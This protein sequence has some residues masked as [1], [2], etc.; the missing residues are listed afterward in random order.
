MPEIIT[1]SDET[2]HTALISEESSA[3]SSDAAQQLGS[4]RFT[5]RAGILITSLVALTNLGCLIWASTLDIEDGS[6]TIFEGSCK[7][8]KRITFWVDLAIN[9][10]STL[11]LG[12]SNNCTQLLVAPT[13]KDIDDAHAAGKYLDVGVSSMRNV[14]AVSRWRQ[15]LCACLFLSS[16]PLHLLYNSVIFST[17]SAS[18]YMAAVV[19]DDFLE[20]AAWNNSRLDLLQESETTGQRQLARL[21]NST[22]QLRRLENKDCIRA[23]GTNVLQ[24]SWKNV[25]V[26]SDANV[27]GPLIRA[28]YH[29][30]DLAANDLSWICG[31]QAI[32]VTSECDTKLMLSNPR[33]WTIR[34]MET[35]QDKELV[36]GLGSS[37]YGSSMFGSGPTGPWFEASVQ[38]CLAEEAKERCGVK[39][40]TP[41]LGTVLLCNLIKVA[42]LTYALLVRDFDPMATVGDLISSYLDDH[43]PYTHGRGPIAD[44]DVRFKP[45]RRLLNDYRELSMET[46]KGNNFKIY[47]LSRMWK[48]GVG[49]VSVN[50]LVGATN[51]RSLIENVLL[52]NTPQLA[53]SF[54]YVF[55][56]NCLTRMMFGQEYSDY[57]RHRI[58]VFDYDGN[59]ITQRISACGFSSM[60]IVL[61][62]FVSGTIILTLLANGARKLEPGMPLASS[63]SLAITAACHTVPGDEDARLSP[64]KYGVVISEESD[65]DNEYEHA[66]FS[67]KKVMPLVDGH[68]YN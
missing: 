8:S 53:I 48:D 14:L 50:Y 16:I 63:C 26:V 47:T 52:A 61:S 68:L 31:K 3:Q 17:L 19:T 10:L 62:L 43:D 36:V 42:C 65:S 37:L 64:L 49:T 28:Y 29:H 25:L 7:E 51:D 41:L 5:V 24:S 27:T 15:W 6:A 21:Q 54:I 1:S 39:I 44:I 34:D 13:R 55:Y 38:Y 56:N 20:G 11:L 67:S 33:D 60:A 59:A 30:V 57:A 58:N 12:A 2:P 35:N 66:C 9:I 46:Y 22:D 4:W 32:A 40:S 45:M 18:S 23:Y